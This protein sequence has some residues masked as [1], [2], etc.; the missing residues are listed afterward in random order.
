MQKMLLNEKFPIFKLDF[1][2]T[3]TNFNSAQE[4]INRLI[5]LIDNN[6]DVRYV[7]EFD[8]YSHTKG[9]QDGEIDESIVDARNVMFCFG[10][11]LTQPEVLAVRPRSIGVA[12]KKDSFTVSFMEAPMVSANQTMEGWVNSLVTHQR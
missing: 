7:G 5:E 2:K 9:L 11:K 4:I 10:R 8:H 12:E 6:K 1:L 3:E